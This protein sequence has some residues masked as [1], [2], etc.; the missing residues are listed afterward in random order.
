MIE[1]VPL[2]LSNTINSLHSHRLINGISDSLNFNFGST[3][4][5]D[6]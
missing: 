5:N 6:S 1:N 3:Y 4:L 2:K